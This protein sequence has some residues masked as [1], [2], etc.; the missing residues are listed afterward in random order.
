MTVEYLPCLYA[1]TVYGVRALLH[2]NVMFYNMWLKRFLQLCGNI[3]KY[4]GTICENCCYSL[5]LRK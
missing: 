3:Y 2:S 5:W 4:L 1:C